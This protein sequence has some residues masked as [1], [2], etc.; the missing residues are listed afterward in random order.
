MN[1]YFPS[2]LVPDLL[3]APGFNSQVQNFKNSIIEYLKNNDPESVPHIEAAIE[4]NAG[5]FAKLVQCCAYIA[6]IYI[7]QANSKAM[8]NFASFAKGQMLD[9]RVSDLGLRRQVIQAEDLSAT[10]PKKLIMETDEALLTRFFLASYSLK[11][12]SRKGYEFH[13][14]TVGDR[15]KIIVDQTI[16]GEVNVKYIF[17]ND[18]NARLVR[19]AA[20]RRVAP[21]EVDVFILAHN[22]IASS[23]LL[24]AISD[25]LHR[26]DIKEE[27]DK[28]NVKAASLVD[29]KIHIRVKNTLNQ[30]PAFI[31]EQLNREFDEFTDK[32][33][34]LEATVRPEQVGGVVYAKNL[35]DYEVLQP[36]Q[37]I[38]T[39]ASSAPNCTGVTVEVY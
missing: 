19:D 10:P 12:G 9:A 6:N 34:R 3:K 28:V 11:P 39:N 7:Q 16:P 30:N 38:S 14:R 35:D 24:T 27:T 23:D 36:A 5:M 26:E 33:R 22:G 20:C 17:S 32:H 8:Q 25:Y 4:D 18:S 13:A 37:P 29:Y 31:E 21:G 1:N 2:P 15:P